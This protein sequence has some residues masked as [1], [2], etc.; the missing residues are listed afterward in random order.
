MSALF[1]AVPALSSSLACGAPSAIDTAPAPPKPTAVASVPKPV[2]VPMPWELSEPQPPAEPMAEFVPE[3]PP[4][5]EGRTLRVTFTPRASS[6]NGPEVQTPCDFTRLYRGGIGALADVSSGMGRTLSAMLNKA[7]SGAITG[8]VHEDRAGGAIRIESGSARDD[9]T[10]LLKL[11]GGD[12]ITG[13]CSEA[14]ILTGTYTSKGKSQ[15]VTLFPRPESW[16]PLYSIERNKKV[17]TCAVSDEGA[18]FFGAKLRPAI[19][20]ALDGGQFQAH[21]REVG[22]CTGT[23]MHESHTRVAFAGDDIIT[24]Q[25]HETSDYGGAHPVHS[26]GSGRTIDLRTGRIVHLADVVTR[27]DALE[28]YMPSCLRDY[29]S[30][31][32]EAG[33]VSVAFEASD[34]TC[35]YP[36]DTYLWRCDKQVKQ[37]VPSWA[38]VEGGIAILA[39][40]HA[41]VEAFRDG[42]GPIIS[43]AALKRDKLVKT[44]SP[45]AR[46]WKDVAPATA[47]APACTSGYRTGSLVRW[48]VLVP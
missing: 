40:G 39:Q 18:R 10:F 20:R 12:R 34:V 37:A 35:D 47:D 4:M 29:V 33:E 2:R 46:L 8:E 25:Y 22:L 30:I 21:V 45:V 23:M 16:P 11:V 42:N 27:I 14:G 1:V 9:G 24:L 48:S 26:V 3:P 36:F 41:H 5:P 7:P 6:M 28:Q 44:K 15:P 13:S 31:D 38:L 19:D 17:K 43:W 32:E